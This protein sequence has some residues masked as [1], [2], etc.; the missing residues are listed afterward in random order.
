VTGRML[1][2]LALRICAALALPAVASAETAPASCT[3]APLHTFSPR[4][5][6]AS[7]GSDFARRVAAMSDSERE[8]AIE[9]EL[10]AGNMPTFLKRLAPVTLLGRGKDGRIVRGT[11]CVLPDYLAIGSDHDFL[12][13][14]MRL[15]TALEV[16]SHYGF[17]LPTP[18]IVDAIY[19]QSAV[20]LLPQP[21]P[22]GNEMRSTGYYQRH[23]ELIGDQR[24]ALGTA[25]GM[26]TAGHKKDIV[27]TNR[28][29]RNPDRVAIYGWH[30]GDHDP[31]QP[32]STVH[33]ARYVDYSHGVR[34]VSTVVYVDGETRSISDVLADPHLAQILSA[35]GPIPRLA[36]LATVLGSPVTDTAAISSASDATKVA[37]A[38]ARR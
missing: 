23:N 10:L 13:V 14:P 9:T 34:L 18:R 21:L 3:G 27:F 29:W 16:A 24:S 4:S 31:I 17:T 19:E 35:E 37:A 22:A 15:A 7:S 30:R 2:F 11:V 5:P 38:G 33:G 25:P 26:L 28:L 20:H 8:Q 12:Y 36:E 32:L 1:G 6:T